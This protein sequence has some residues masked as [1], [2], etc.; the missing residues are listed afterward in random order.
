MRITSGRRWPIALLYVVGLALLVEGA[1]YLIVKASDNDLG[2]RP[3][4]H[5][6]SAI[7]GHELNPGYRAPPIPRGA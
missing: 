6:Y 3:Q 2:D 4:R 7:R 5:L 1:G